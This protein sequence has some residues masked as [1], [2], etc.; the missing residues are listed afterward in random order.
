[1]RLYRQC[2]AG[3]LAAMKKMFFVSSSL[4]IAI[5]FISSMAGGAPRA[6]AASIS[7]WWPIDGAHMQ[8]MQP[9][10]A[11][12]DGANLSSY[13]LYWQVDGGSLNPM[14]NS[15][16]DSP[17]KEASVNLSGW[18][19]RGVG[20]YAVTF[21]AKQ[22]GAVVAQTTVHIYNDAAAA[23]ATSTAPAAVP[24]ATTTAAPV[25]A[26]AATFYVNPNSD[27]A[28]Q[29]K[30]WSSS[31]PAD[32]A[33]MQLLASQPTAIWLGNWSGDVTAAASSD[34]K[35]AGGKTTVFVA[36]D[37]PQRDCGGYSAGGAQDYLSWISSLA[38]GIGSSNADIILEPDALAQISCLSSADQAARLSL[39]S[40]AVTI[41]K[42]NP[43]TK[44]YLDAG[45]ANWIDASTMA[46]LLQKANVSQA[47]GFSLNVSNYDATAAEE[48]YGASVSSKIGGKHFVIDTSRNGTGS[49][50]QWCNATGAAIGTYPTTST[51]N[52]LVDAFLWIKTPGESDGTCNGG[53]S[54]GTWWPDYA[55]ALVNN[56]HL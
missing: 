41:L 17:H 20:P 10:K 1:M 54:A 11:V 39:L 9:F 29:A 56:A 32:A 34:V 26:T 13:D 19:W 52:P 6:H 55:L 14:Q 46:S 50:G 33:K 43:N 45:H 30:A 12:L 44:V 24:A 5:I 35:A 40:Q 47:D 25:T 8:G 53:P 51:G 36:Y 18:N 38:A 48:A 3:I 4:L 22:N 2:R 31:R 21:V 15:S 27:A 16:T 42:K 7:T 23:T 28:N 49:N 37:I